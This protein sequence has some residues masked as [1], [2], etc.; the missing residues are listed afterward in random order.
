[1]DLIFAYIAGLLTLI[2]PCVLPV[3]PI[4]LAT[5][6]NATKTVGPGDTVWIHAGTYR[7]G[8]ASRLAGRPGK[9]R[10]RARAS[11]APAGPVDLVGADRWQA[12]S[13]RQSG[14]RL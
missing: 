2:N 14:S 9:G 3:L 5:A 10:F 1:M 11:S 13:S 6:L 8:F 4:V 7:G 12:A